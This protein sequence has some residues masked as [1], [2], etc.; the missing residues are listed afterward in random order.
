MLT[1]ELDVVKE[2]DE[3]TR[4]GVKVAVEIGITTEMLHGHWRLFKIA[5]D[6]LKRR[7][8]TDGA[9]E[10]SGMFFEINLT[11]AIRI[12]RTINL[13]IKCL[14]QEV[15]EASSENEPNLVFCNFSDN[16]IIISYAS[17]PNFGTTLDLTKFEM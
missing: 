13:F 16:N 4:T 7:K 12:I 17:N 2:I 6:T 10:M 8:W 3:R 11:K 14:T 9:R 1:N 15:L 5:I